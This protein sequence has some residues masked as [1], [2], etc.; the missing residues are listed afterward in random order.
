MNTEDNV[1]VKL[2]KGNFIYPEITENDYRFGVVATPVIREDGDWRDYLPPEELQRRDGIESSACFIEAQ[3]HIIATI[4]EEEYG[5]KDQNYSARFNMLYTDAAPFGGSPIQA[6]QSFRHEGLIPD[7]MLPFSND[8]TSWE[9]FNSWEGGNKTTC[10]AAGKQFLKRWALNWQIVFEIDEPKESKLEKLKKAL[11]YSPVAISVPAWFS[12]GDVYFRPNEERDNH[13][14]MCV[15]MDDNYLYVFDTYE[16][17]IKKLD[18]NINPEFAIRW[19]VAKLKTEQA[20]ESLITLII[21]VLRKLK[22]LNE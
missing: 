16:P 18:R 4:I 5:I 8:I 15:Y 11:K 3:Q 13:L 19:S 2:I 22:L 17:F 7:S 10:L 9:E 6:A 12:R 20:S 1:E 21:N 14:V